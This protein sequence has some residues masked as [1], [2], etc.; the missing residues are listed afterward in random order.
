MTDITL[1][2]KILDILDGH[3]SQDTAVTREQL[4]TNTK[5]PDRL[6]RDCIAE[7]QGDGFPIVSLGKGYWLG[8]KEEVRRYAMREKFRALTILKKIRG[9][10]PV[11]TIIN[12]LE[13]F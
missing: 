8:S 5:A 10:L 13:M 9:F 11:Q 3:R 1:K 12:Q 2:H 6:I 7:L 4:E